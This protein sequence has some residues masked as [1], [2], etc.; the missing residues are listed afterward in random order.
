MKRNLTLILTAAL[1][2]LILSCSVLKRT[3]RPNAD[4]HPLGDSASVTDGSLIYV[5]PMTVF[6]ISFDLERTVSIPG[7]YSKYAYDML[8]IKDAILTQSESWSISGIRLSSAEEID[9]SE[10]YVI[11]SSSLSLQNALKL[12]RNGLILD[13]NPATYNREGTETVRHQNDKGLRGFRDLGSDEYFVAQ[14]DTVYKT[15]KLD[16]TFVK[17]P[18]L[19]EKKKILSTDQLVERAAK[20]LLDLREGKHSILSGDA[21]VYPQNSAAIDELNRMEKELSELFAGKTLTEKRTLVFTVIPKKESAGKPFTLF[22]FSAKDGIL[23]G[24]SQGGT[25]VTAELEPAHKTKDITV[26]PRSAESA[27]NTVSW[28]KLFYRLPDIATIRVKLD[29][30]VLFENRR[31]VDQFGEVLQLPSNFI[32][33]N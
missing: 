23:N 15:V 30:Q 22:R 4:I 14:N 25:P 2:T 12:K 17:I 1:C 31:L 16:S 32:I 9:P 5:L 20:S 27:K 18:Y 3:T 6:T 29:G 11:E 19:V 7:P 10:Y 24:T 28:D 33:G 26:I 13:L 8:G 21:N